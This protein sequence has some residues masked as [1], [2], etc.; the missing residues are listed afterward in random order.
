MTIEDV[1]YLFCH[2]LICNNVLNLFDKASMRDLISI[3]LRKECS[4]VFAA[5]I[6]KLANLSFAEGIVLSRSGSPRSHHVTSEEAVLSTTYT[7][8]YRP[9]PT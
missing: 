8:S 5:I 7:A 3:T 2:L 1:Q 9:I 6:T 4:L